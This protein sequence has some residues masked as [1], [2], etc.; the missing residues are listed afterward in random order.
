MAGTGN[1]FN[2]SQQFEIVPHQKGKAYPISVNEWVF[3][4]SKIKGINIE[5][6]NFYWI[7][8]LLLGA[9]ASCL[10]TIIVTDFKNDYNAKYITWSF[11]S[12]SLLTGLLCLYFAKDKHKQEEIKPDEIISQME[13]IESRFET[14]E[15]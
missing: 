3:I 15:G 9:C 7:G 10:I 5:I 14:G 11:F 2:V 12:V 8:F 13:L 1:K 4:K 6:N